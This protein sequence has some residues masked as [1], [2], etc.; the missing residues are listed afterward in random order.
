MKVKIKGLR[1]SGRARHAGSKRLS[2]A[3]RRLKVVKGARRRRGGNLSLRKRRGI[4]GRYR[5]RRGAR[6]FY[7]ASSQ[8]YNQGYSQAYDEGFK[9]GFAKGYEDGQ[10][11]PAPV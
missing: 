3:V 6:V 1:K 8:A 5:L 9:S 11:P 4:R 7:P 2:L 10:I